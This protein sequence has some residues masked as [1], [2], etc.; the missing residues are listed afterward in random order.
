VLDLDLAP[1]STPLIVGR[2]PADLGALAIPIPR[3]E[4]ACCACSLG[5]R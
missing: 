4:S 1:N 3:R 2:Q 5:T